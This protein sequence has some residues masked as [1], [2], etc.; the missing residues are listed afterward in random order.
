[1][2]ELFAMSFEVL[3]DGR[4][5]DMLS[6][7]SRVTDSEAYEQSNGEVQTGYIDL[8]FTSQQVV[9][10][11]FALYQNT[12]NP[13]RNTTT[14]GFVMPV[15]Q[16]A[17]LTI[18]EVSG[19]VVFTTEGDFAAGYNE[20]SLDKKDLPVAGVLYYRID[21]EGFTGVKKMILIE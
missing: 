17:S 9:D 1:M 20:I 12:P 18:F 4:L 7:S 15:E 10:A 8:A 6:I 16:H 21:T 5:H 13:F 19:K 3:R 11:E 14:I 2:K